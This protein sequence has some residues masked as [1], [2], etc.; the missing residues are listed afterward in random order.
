MRLTTAAMAGVGLM[1]AT[2]MPAQ[3]AAEVKIYPYHG[4]N[5]CPAG[6]QPVQINGVI[7]CGNPNQSHSYSQMLAHPMP[8]KKRVHKH[9]HTHTHKHTHKKKKVVYS[10]R[11]HC[12]AGQ[13]GC[14]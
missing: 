2:M 8:K 7:C 10:A 6:F 1:M 12:P 5:Y 3:V 13:K 14:S 4:A 11:A 9:R